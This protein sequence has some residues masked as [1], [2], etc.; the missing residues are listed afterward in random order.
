MTITRATNVIWNAS[1]SIPLL[2]ILLSRPVM[3]LSGILVITQIIIKTIVTPN[4]TAY[5]STFSNHWNNQNIR[6]ILPATNNI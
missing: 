6:P 3:K 5:G 2:P 4:P 1:V